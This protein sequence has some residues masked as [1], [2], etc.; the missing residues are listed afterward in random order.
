MEV[1]ENTKGLTTKDYYKTT[2]VNQH[3]AQKRRQKLALRA[4]YQTEQ[5][6][7][8]EEGTELEVPIGQLTHFILPEDISEDCKCWESTSYGEPMCAGDACLPCYIAHIVRHHGP[9]HMA[10]LQDLIKTWQGGSL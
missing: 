9:A 10:K 1:Q 8:W 4:L 2:D 3:A 5:M 7:N 6:G